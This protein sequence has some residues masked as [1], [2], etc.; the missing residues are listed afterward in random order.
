ML[1]GKAFLGL[2]QLLAVM[3]LMIF[4]PAGTWRYPE[5]WCF[6]LVFATW[7]IAISLSTRRPSWRAS[8]PATRRTARG[9]ATAWCPASGR[10]CAPR[11]GGTADDSIE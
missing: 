1:K 3:G 2:A 10:R 8:F 9:S 4:V 5:G 7:A 11:I 6:L